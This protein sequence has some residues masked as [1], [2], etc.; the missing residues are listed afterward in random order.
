M[1]SAHKFGLKVVDTRRY[2]LSNDPREREQNN[3]RLL[4][5]DAGYDAVFIADAAGEFGRYVPFATALPRPV[6]GAEGLIASSW[7]W[8]FERHGAPQLNQ[9]IRRQSDREPTSEDW[10]TWAAVRSVVEASVQAGSIDGAV[11]RKRMLADDFRLDLYKIGAGSY[12]SWDHQLRQPIMLHTHNAVIA[13]AP[14]EGFLHQFHAFDSLGTDE[15]E[16]QCRL[17]AP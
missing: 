11:L 13:V 1:A 5:G 17:A 12:R 10:A 6:V 2:I 4:T 14:V 8:T 9:R 15:P 3:L 7:H 16:S